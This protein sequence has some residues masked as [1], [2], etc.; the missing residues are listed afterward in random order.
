MRRNGTVVA[1]AEQMLPALDTAAGARRGR[2]RV[3][4]R[5]AELAARQ[6]HPARPERAGR[7]IGRGLASA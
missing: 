6:R 2:G 1:T 4:R 7:A 5:V 3:R